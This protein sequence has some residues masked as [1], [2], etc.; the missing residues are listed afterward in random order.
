[1]DAANANRHSGNG[2]RRPGR[3]RVPLSVTVHRNDRVHARQHGSAT[4][5]APN[6]HPDDGGADS[7][8]AA[9]RGEGPLAIHTTPEAHPP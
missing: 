6:G 2:V 8:R 1:M 7:G 3:L 4:L 9:P 5:S